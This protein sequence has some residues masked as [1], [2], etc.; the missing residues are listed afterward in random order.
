MVKDKTRCSGKMTEAQFITFVKNQLRGASWKWSPTNEVV[1]EARTR[2]G[3]YLCNGCKQEVPA[4]VVVNGKR[5]KGVFVDHEPPV[6]DPTT[7][8][9]GWDSFINRLYCERDHLQLL[10]KT[11]HDIKSAGE[12]ELAKQSKKDKTIES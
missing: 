10:C 4:S 5:V 9:V 7:G 6:I 12:R 11:C 8:F 3:W 2:K 1:K